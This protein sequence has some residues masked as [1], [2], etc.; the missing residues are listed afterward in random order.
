MG[1]M[2]GKNN[3]NNETTQYH[4]GLQFQEFDHHH[5]QNQ[6][7]LAETIDDDA[8]PNVDDDD[9]YAAPPEYQKTKPQ[10]Q[11]FPPPPP[12]DD[13]QDYF[14][15]FPPQ[16][17]DFHSVPQAFPPVPDES[18]QQFPPPES[19]SAPEINVNHQFFSAQPNFGV[20]GVPAAVNIGMSPAPLIPQTIPNPEWKTSLFDCMENPQNGTLSFVISV[21]LECSFCHIICPFEFSITF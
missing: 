11:A 21:D 6:T 9:L 4:Q 2:P 13:E 15:S 3:D 14:Q 12:P 10:P 17:N 18:T 5:H 8:P 1:R 16:H 7:P 20:G 19:M